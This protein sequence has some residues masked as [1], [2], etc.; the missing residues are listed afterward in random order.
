MSSHNPYPSELEESLQHGGRQLLLRP[1]RPEDA[2]LH[3][4][5]LAR[6]APQDLYTRFFTT[7]R[8]LPE[9]DIAHLT[10]IDYDREMAF[11]AVA[12]DSSGVEE[13]LAVA[14][15]CADPDDR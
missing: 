4:R 6:I 14:R 11:V 13:I 3:R 10:Q 1:I 15:A 2:P 12:V 7:V 9:A 8:Q 5:F